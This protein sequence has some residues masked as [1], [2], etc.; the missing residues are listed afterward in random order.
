MSFDSLDNNIFNHLCGF[1]GVIDLLSIILVDKKRKDMVLKNT[2]LMKRIQMEMLNINNIMQYKY[3]Y[4][5]GRNNFA[6]IF[7]SKNNYSYNTTYNHTIDIK[8]DSCDLARLVNSG[9]LLNNRFEFVLDVKLK[10]IEFANDKLKISEHDEEIGYI[11]RHLRMFLWKC[12]V[13]NFCS[14]LTVELDE[15]TTFHVN[16]S[17]NTIDFDTIKSRIGKSKEDEHLRISFVVK[18][19]K[20][21]FKVKVKH[22][23]ADIEDGVDYY[24]YVKPNGMKPFLIDF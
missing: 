3:S 17:Y 22:V 21:L 6:K 10:S 1:L 18:R 12:G 8:D 9:Y 20:N 7:L 19:V 23:I 13:R 4:T 14:P 16:R 5:L 11:F 2:V 24:D 15:N